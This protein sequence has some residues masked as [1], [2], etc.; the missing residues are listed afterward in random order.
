[1]ILPGKRSYAQVLDEGSSRLEIQNPKKTKTTSPEAEADGAGKT[2]SELAGKEKLSDSSEAAAN[3]KEDPQSLSQRLVGEETAA[4]STARV[5]FVEAKRFDHWPRNEGLS[6][7]RIQSTLDYLEDRTRNKVTIGLDVLIPTH[8]NDAVLMT[9]QRLSQVNPRDWRVNFRDTPGE[10]LRI[11]LAAFP[12]QGLQKDMTEELMGVKLK[13]TID[14]PKYAHEYQ[15]SCSNI[16]MDHRGPDAS[17]SD[18]TGEESKPVIDNFKNKT[19][20]KV[21]KPAGELLSE[22]IFMINKHGEIPKDMFSLCSKFITIATDV[23]ECCETARKAGMTFPESHSEF[24]KK[25]KL[26]ETRS[27]EK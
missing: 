16:I 14:N 19:L 24:S 4:K 10:L 8:V 20:K 2:T 27:D 7:K 6:H 17:I 13:V 9:L 23:A 21:E 11:L 25:R 15:Q 3:K 5:E 18:M 22:R 26:E 1:M 12:I